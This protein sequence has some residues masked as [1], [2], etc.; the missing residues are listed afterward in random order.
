MLTEQ[1]RQVNWRFDLPAELKPH[2]A[3]RA[4]RP[5]YVVAKRLLDLLLSSGLALL[6]APLASVYLV[7]LAFRRVALFKSPRVGLRNRVFLAYSFVPTANWRGKKAEDLRL[8]NWPLLWNVWKGDMSLVGPRAVA[9][10]DPLTHMPVVAAR[11]TT[12]PGLVCLHWLRHRANIAYEGE[13]SADRE[14]VAGQSLRN[15]LAI[16]LRA[17]IT[18]CYGPAKQANADRIT[19][20]GMKIDNLSMAGAIEDILARLDAPTPSQVC[21]VNADCANIAR[22]NR[23]YRDVLN[24]A[25]LTLADGIGMRIAGNRLGQPIREN[26]CGTDLFPRLCQALE[27]TGKGV[28]LLG[29]H[30]GVAEGVVRWMAQNYRGVQISGH[31]HG[32]YSAAEESEVIRQIADS[33]ASLLLV[34][35]GAPRQD[36]WIHVHLAATG[37]KVAMGVGGLFDYYSG[38]IPRAP[39]WV[40]ELGL[41]WFFRFW[42]EPRRLARRYFIGNGVFL[43]HVLREWIATKF[44]KPTTKP[45]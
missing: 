28:F 7:L 12:R 10:G 11:F 20:Q 19:I 43:W 3:A 37:V 32:Y 1:L 4:E 29:G 33:G 34:A 18:L 15:D 26:L 8:R 13:V 5:G 23:D 36:Q 39:R 9:P 42:Q 31:R 25:D 21:F 38:R 41:E 17:M 22:K 2:G 30:P 14:Y 44:K 35:F 24:S 27:G 40:R 6:I 16:L 45:A